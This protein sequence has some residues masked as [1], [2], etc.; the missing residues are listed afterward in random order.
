MP[1]DIKDPAQKEVAVLVLAGREPTWLK[2]WLL[3]PDTIDSAL[4]DI[5]IYIYIYYIYTAEGRR[6]GRREEK[7]ATNIREDSG[8][9]T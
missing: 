8:K 9:S 3:C 5:C 4:E 6:E 2:L 1:G 7:H